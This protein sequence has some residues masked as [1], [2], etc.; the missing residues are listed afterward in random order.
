MTEVTHLAV[1]ADGVWSIVNDIDLRLTK[2]V[3]TLERQTT[4]NRYDPDY[5]KGRSLIH[6]ARRIS[7]ILHKKHKEVN[8]Y[9][10]Y[11]DNTMEVIEPRRYTK[12]I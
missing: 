11:S 7:K 1:E 5:L 4:G 10:V 6:L 8:I 2:L 9:A 3:F 12:V